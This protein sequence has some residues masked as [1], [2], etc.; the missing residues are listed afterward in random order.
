MQTN[1]TAATITR[2]G[3]S[4]LLAGSWSLSGIEG[5]ETDIK[6]IATTIPANIQID[7]S[8]ITAMDTAGAWLYYK[9]LGT[10]SKH[11]KKFTEV[12]LDHEYQQLIDLIK[13]R[14]AIMGPIPE[15]IEPGFLERVGIFS[16][17]RAKLFD[18]WLTFFGELCVRVFG[19]IC[20]P[21]RFR[22]KYFMSNLEINGF[23]AI[24]IIAFLSFLIG[25]V[26]TY[27]TGLQL[28]NYGANIYIIGLLGTAT[29]REFAPLISAIIITGRTGSAFTAQLGVM[30][31]N[32]EIDA[33]RTMG[34]S[35]MELLVIPRV[36]GLIV[37]L[38]LLI[39][40]ADIFG[41]LGGMVMAKAILD[42]GYTTFIS[43][44]PTSVTLTSFTI[45]MVKA[46]VFA[47]II[48]TIGCYEGF[49]VSGSSE[50]IGLQTT[51]SVVLAT[52]MIIIADA[53]FAIVLSWLNI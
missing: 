16:V 23:R 20:Q 48:A 19:I 34:H 13:K 3:N 15:K 11:N 49:R 8:G 17:E 47:I 35:P 30:K 53:A 7:C 32:E 45:G 50:S 37:A 42:I 29:F 26:L 12:N 27:E 9:L 36:F 52:F 6:S 14:T 44:F 25:V 46:P 31:V 38:P 18:E 22:W 1:I 5:L 39:V 51:K 21:S 33:L 2:S 10:L 24:P 28:R 4:L 41:I 40:C 43:H